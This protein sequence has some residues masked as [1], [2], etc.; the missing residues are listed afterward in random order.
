MKLTYIG[1]N[2]GS[3]K[4]A[5]RLI[6]ALSDTRD[7]LEDCYATGSTYGRLSSLKAEECELMASLEMVMRCD[8]VHATTLPQDG[9]H[10][11]HWHKAMRPYRVAYVAQCQSTRPAADPDDVEADIQ[12]NLAYMAETGVRWDMNAAQA[13]LI[14]QGHDYAVFGGVRM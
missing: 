2:N 6:E 9:Q 13:Y 7:Q 14:E 12:Q 4:E 8:A 11:Y 3:I 1:M 10:S 5:H